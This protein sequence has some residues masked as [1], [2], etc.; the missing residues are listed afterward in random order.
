[1]VLKWGNK[2]QNRERYI[3]GIN[4]IKELP[5]RIDSPLLTAF[6]H[7]TSPEIRNIN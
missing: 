1:M 7:F 4:Q 5:Y 2:A 6:E 3:Q